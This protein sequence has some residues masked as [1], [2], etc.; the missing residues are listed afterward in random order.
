[1]AVRLV[2]AVYSAC[3]LCV[4][5]LCC[6]RL[7][8]RQYFAQQDCEMTYMYRWPQYQACQQKH[9]VMTCLKC[10]VPLTRRCPFRQKWH[11]DF[12]SMACTCITNGNMHV[13]NI[14][15]HFTCSIPSGKNKH[16]HSPCLCPCRAF[17][18]CSSPAMQAVTSRHAPLPP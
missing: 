2:G 7:C 6:L 12:L 14:P 16:P 4:V 3:V 9:V 13:P 18:L 5:V 11:Q 10:V 8:Y 17:R 1:M 15:L